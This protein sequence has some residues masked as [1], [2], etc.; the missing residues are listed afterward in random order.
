[1]KKRNI[2][3]LSLL[4]AFAGAAAYLRYIPGHTPAGQP[5]LVNLDQASFDRQFRAAAAGPRVLVLVS[6]T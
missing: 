3:L 5:P 6:P 4:L 2:V 1:V